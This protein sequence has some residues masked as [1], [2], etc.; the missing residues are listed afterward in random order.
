MDSLEKFPE[1]F[2]KRVMERTTGKKQ[3]YPKS[4]GEDY[5]FYSQ[6]EEALGI[7]YKRYP[8]GSPSLRI[9]LSNG[10]VALLRKMSDAEQAVAVEPGI[11]SIQQ[12]AAASGSPTAHETGSYVANAVLILACCK[13]DGQ[14]LSMDKLLQLPFQDWISL[15]AAALK[16]HAD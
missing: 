11:R 1:A 9:K 10:Q 8:N 5:A 7:E 3:D 2:T 14:L 16:I 15:E 6:Q 12:K 4:T 13:F